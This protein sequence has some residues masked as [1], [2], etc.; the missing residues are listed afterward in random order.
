MLG[1]RDQR[2]F[3]KW[4]AGLELMTDVRRLPLSHWDGVWDGVRGPG[5]LWS[6][7]RRMCIEVARL[8]RLCAIGAGSASAG[9]HNYPR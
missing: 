5:L 4:E 8:A 6:V 9:Q 2:H 1:L 7:Q 3:A